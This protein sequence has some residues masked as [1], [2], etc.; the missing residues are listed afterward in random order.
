[1]VLWD[2]KGASQSWYFTYNANTDDYIIE[3]G[4]KVLGVADGQVREGSDVVL[5][6]RKDSCNQ[7]WKIYK[8]DDNYTFTSACSELVLDVAGGSLANGANIQLWSSNNTDAQ[9]WVLSRVGQ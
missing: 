9:K 1:M 6:S 3:I 2:E 4:A 8:K 5:A 7:R